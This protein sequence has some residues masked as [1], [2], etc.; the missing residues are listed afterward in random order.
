MDAQLER[1]RESLAVQAEAARGGD[2][3]RFL[4]VLDGRIDAGTDRE[5]ALSLRQASPPDQLWQGLER[6]WRKRAEAERAA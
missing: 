1:V 3:D 5:T 6:Y 4:E 2:R